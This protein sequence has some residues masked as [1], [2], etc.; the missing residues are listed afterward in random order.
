MRYLPHLSNWNGEEKPVHR[1]HQRP[2]NNRAVEFPRCRRQDF[3]TTSSES[4]MEPD[5]RDVRADHRERIDVPRREIS[6]F[7]EHNRLPILSIHFCNDR[8]ESEGL[9]RSSSHRTVGQH[10]SRIPRKSPLLPA[11]SHQFPRKHVSTIEMP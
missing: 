10:S 3:S 4:Q 5:E 6:P 8:K 9:S 2:T 11:S 7:F 1:Q